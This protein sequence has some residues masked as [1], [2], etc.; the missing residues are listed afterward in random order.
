MACHQGSFHHPNN[1]AMSRAVSAPSNDRSP[2]FGWN[3]QFQ[4]ESN[5]ATSPEY[6]QQVERTPPSCKM[7]RVHPAD[8]SKTDNEKLA[9]TESSSFNE[10]MESETARVQLRLSHMLDGYYLTSWKDLL[11][12]METRD[13]DIKRKYNE[14][15][16]SSN[17]IEQ[18]VLYMEMDARLPRFSCNLHKSLS[19]MSNSSIA[20]VARL[21]MVQFPALIDYMI[22]A[23]EESRHGLSNFLRDFL[24]FKKNRPEFPSGSGREAAVVHEY[25][26]LIVDFMIKS[27]QTEVLILKKLLNDLS[28]ARGLKLASVS[29]GRRSSAHEALEHIMTQH[30]K[31]QMLPPSISENMPVSENL[32]TSNS[33][34]N[35]EFEKKNSLSDE[36]LVIVTE[37]AQENENF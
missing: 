2:I 5:H 4:D 31:Y 1:A 33:L 35:A 6:I 28:K 37:D 13:E 22:I 8:G 3:S 30:S 17:L 20:E 24:E 7:N 15:N 34:T 25:E 16:E 19:A 23:Q 27:D 9:R 26:S 10:D 29:G 21:L 36:N 18:E 11:I 12:E 32:E 14:D